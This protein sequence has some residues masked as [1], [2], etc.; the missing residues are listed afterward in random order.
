MTR[1]PRPSLTPP[2][3]SPPIL[4]RIRLKVK[5]VYLDLT[6]S[7]QEREWVRARP[8]IESIEGWMFPEEE[9]WLFCTAYELPS[10]ANIV[11]IGSFKG[12]STCA[13]ASG[14]RGTRKRIFAIDTFDG[15]GWDLDERD[16]FREFAQNLQRCSAS[17]Y[18]EPIRGVSTEIAR[19]WASPIHLLF[20]DG[21]HEYDAAKGDFESFFPH[22]V[23]GGVVAFHDVSEAFPGVWRLWHETA[24][25]Q[26]ASVGYCKSLGHGRKAV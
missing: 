2:S 20:I 14:C 22:V 8:L 16:F 13:L 9:Q 5:R 23:P 25:L 26:L 19:T 4:R 12:R 21:A 15:N 3:T 17:E 11:E 10:P 24:K 7:R 1:T 6:G 18:V